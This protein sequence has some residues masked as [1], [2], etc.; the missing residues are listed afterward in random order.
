MTDKRYPSRL[1]R[2]FRWLRWKPL[3]GLYAGCAITG[4]LLT[5]ARIPLAERNGR[6]TRR[7]WMRHIWR[8]YMSL[9]SFETRNVQTFD[10]LPEE[11][12]GKTR[13]DGRRD[14]EADQPPTE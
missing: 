4:W 2:V 5:G 13:E 6:P 12:N 8:L 7:A 1:V 14:R 10:E 9:A 11:Q 3:Y